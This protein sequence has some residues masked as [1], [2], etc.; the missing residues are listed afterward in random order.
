MD[1]SLNQPILI[2]K[3]SIQNVSL[4][5]GWRTKCCGWLHHHEA[6][7]QLLFVSELHSL[8]SLRFQHRDAAATQTKQICQRCASG[9]GLCWSQWDRAAFHRP[10]GR[11]ITAEDLALSVGQT[12]ADTE[13]NPT[14][15]Y[16]WW[17]LI[18]SGVFLEIYQPS[19]YLRSNNL[20]VPFIVHLHKFTSCSTT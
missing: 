19:K 7:S 2:L 5:G 20:K 16:M 1:N 17:I 12:P 4:H 14:K 9:L 15:Y 3:W 18:W 6:W 10:K 11:E 13:W 8:L